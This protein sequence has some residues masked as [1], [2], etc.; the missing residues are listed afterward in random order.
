VCFVWAQVLNAKNIHKEMFPI[1]GGK[2]LS[3]KAV[4]NWVEKFCEERSKVADDARPG[5]PVEIATE[6]TVQRVEEFIRADRKIII[7]SV[8]T[9]RGCSHG[10]AYS[11]MHDRLKFRKLCARWVPRKLKDREKINRMGMTLQHLLR[12]A[13]EGEDMFNR[14][15]NGCITTNPYESVLQCNRNI[16]VHLQP[17]S[18]RLRHQLKRLCLPC[19]GI[20]REYC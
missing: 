18:L 10:L 8:A 7:D 5:R 4:H 16:P 11:L 6:A 19:F 9:A 12:Y 13:D 3:R 20:L 1:Y 14:I 2:C 17:K 15:V